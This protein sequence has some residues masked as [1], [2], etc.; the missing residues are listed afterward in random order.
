MYT[1]TKTSF[2]WLRHEF[3]WLGPALFP[4]VANSYLPSF[5]VAL[6]GL[7]FDIVKLD[8]S[9]Q[10]DEASFW[11][12]VKRAFSM[13]NYFSSGWDAFEDCWRDDRPELIRLAVLWDSADKAASHVLRLYSEAVAMLHGNAVG[14]SGVGI[15]LELILGGSGDQFRQ[16]G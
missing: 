15:Q 11:S 9:R 3:P 14:L 4:S 6:A 12:E 5:A 2:V 13:P 7:G 16:P 8:G 10:I 1:V